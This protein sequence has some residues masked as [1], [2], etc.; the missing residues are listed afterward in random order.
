MFLDG[1]T[2]RTP[3]F[4]WASLLLLAVS[5]GC[6][7]QNTEDTAERTTVVFKH[8]RIFGDPEPLKRLIERFEREN[9]DLHVVDQTLPSSTDE[10]HQFY[11]INLEGDSRAFDV[12]ALDVIWGPEFARAGWLRDLSHLVPPLVRNDF[13]SGPMEAAAYD[14]RIYAV[15]WYIDAGVLYYR[16]DLLED[17]G[18][19]PPKTWRELVE[20]AV[21]VTA[22]EPGMYGFVWQGKQYEGLVCNVLEY[23]WGNGGS[24]LDGNGRPV[25]DSPRNREALGFVRD[26]IHRYGVTPASVAVATEETARRIFG[27]GKA[28]FMRNWPYAIGLLEQEGSPVRGKVGMM[29]LPSFGKE[30]ASTLGGWMLAVNAR[31]ENPEAAER[32]L[33]FMT[34]QEAQKALSLSAGYRAARKALYQDPSVLA[35]Q[36]F[37]RDLHE[38]FLHARPRPLSPRYLKISQILQAEFSAV[39][40]DVK[41]PGE[42]LAAAQEQLETALTTR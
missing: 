24:V 31:S 13:F 8:G 22:A 18:F 7:G 23:L 21:A 28:V 39:L 40:A 5:F 29:P 14:G 2:A 16:K 4:L 42:A 26:L 35:T 10:Q 6:T 11:V 25:I 9:P 41:T 20:T 17:H 36:P 3:V 34:S 15:P 27:H 1:K 12:L 37:T 38:V 32:F 19:P 33:L 30:R